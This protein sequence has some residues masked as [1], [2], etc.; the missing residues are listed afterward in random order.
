MPQWIVRF[1]IRQGLR[2]PCPWCFRNPIRVD[3]IKRHAEAFHFPQHC[4]VCLRIQSAHPQ[5]GT[6]PNYYIPC[7]GGQ[8]VTEVWQ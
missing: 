4:T 5:S 7:E 1:L 6:S 3:A 8:F 2:V